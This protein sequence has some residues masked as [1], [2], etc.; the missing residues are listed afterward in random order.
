MTSQSLYT[1]D[2]IG[3]RGI[4]ARAVVALRTD[5]SRVDLLSPP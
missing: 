1:A 3:G 2:D 5:S 4:Q